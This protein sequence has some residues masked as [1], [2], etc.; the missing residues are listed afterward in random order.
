LQ[1]GG[2]NKGI[3]HAE[4]VI[5]FANGENSVHGAEYVPV[6]SYENMSDDPIVNTLMDK[7]S[8]FVSVGDAV[9]GYNAS[10][11]NSKYLC[12][13]VAQL[14]LELGVEAFGQDYDIVLGGG[15]LSTRSPYDLKAGDVTY[16]QLQTLFP[17]DN[18]IVLCSIKGSDLITRFIN[19]QDNRYFVH[20]SEYGSTVKEKI[21]PNGTYYVIVDT[22]TSTYAPNRLSEIIRYTEGI[23]AR[24]ILAQYIEDGNLS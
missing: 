15:Y 9:L 10:A 3:S 2:D 14:Y 8:D 12:N 4:A 1:N 17:F 21:D 11:R 18:T 13:L 5:N 22:Y 23:Y 7:Y 20:Y 24:D 6:R 19:S 16:S